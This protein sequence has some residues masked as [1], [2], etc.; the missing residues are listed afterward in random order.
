MGVVSGLRL[1]L[2]HGD[3]S[4]GKHARLHPTSIV[5][6]PVKKWSERGGGERRAEEFREDDQRD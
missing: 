6:S 3:T 5:C 1:A 2:R 4:R